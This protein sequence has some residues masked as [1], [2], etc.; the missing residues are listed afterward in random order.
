[1][2][3]KNNPSII[4]HVEGGFGR[5]ATFPLTATEIAQIWD[6][7]IDHDWHPVDGK[8]TPPP[9]VSVQLYAPELMPLPT[10]VEGYMTD[11]GEWIAIR[12]D[13]NPIQPTHWCPMTR[14]PQI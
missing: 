11:K 14:P 1:M 5:T 7:C 9:F 10:V 13:L 4:R 8:D 6:W 12:T 2:S 3:S